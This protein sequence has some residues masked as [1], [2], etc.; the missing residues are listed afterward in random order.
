VP[1][2]DKG[3]LFFSSKTINREKTAHLLMIFNEMAKKEHFLLPSSV[4]C[5]SKDGDRKYVRKCGQFS[6]LNVRV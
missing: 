2:R 3:T 5:Q 1:I 6:L 4:G